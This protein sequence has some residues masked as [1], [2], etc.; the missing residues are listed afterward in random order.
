MK[1]YFSLQYVS[2]FENE[3]SEPKDISSYLKEVSFDKKEIQTEEYLF[4]FEKKKGQ[5][6]SFGLHGEEFISNTN[7]KQIKK[8]L[9]EK[10]DI[11][12]KML[13]YYKDVVFHGIFKNDLYSV[14]S[15]VYLDNGFSPGLYET[16][17]VLSS[18]GLDFVSVID[19]KVKKENINFKNA[20]LTQRKGISF[21]SREFYSL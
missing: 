13:S 4:A 1:D 18:L 2:Y 7:D 17:N 11:Y 15:L 10:Y 12:N 21:F 8:I 14:F 19:A 3:A 16:A 6:L 9:E 20:I 5:Y